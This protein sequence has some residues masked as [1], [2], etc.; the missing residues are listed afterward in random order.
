MY[1]I[2]SVY[3]MLLYVVMDTFETRA[4]RECIPPPQP[5]TSSIAYQCSDKNP[6]KMLWFQMVVQI[7]P[8]IELYVF[9]CY[10]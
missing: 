7:T 5:S 4:L 1:T 9:L 8:R 6:L 10:C 2:N 3:C